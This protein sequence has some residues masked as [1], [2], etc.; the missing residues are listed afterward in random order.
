M[1][2]FSSAAW[3]GFAVLSLILG[4]WNLLFWLRF[5]FICLFVPVLKSFC[6]V[7]LPGTW[8]VRFSLQSRSSCIG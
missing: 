2:A 3:C 6:V 5:P 4:F 8:N 1:F 7:D